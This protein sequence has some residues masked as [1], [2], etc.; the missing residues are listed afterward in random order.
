MAE[1]GQSKQQQQHVVEVDH[2]EQI[3]IWSIVCYCMF[4]AMLLIAVI[5]MCVNTPPEANSVEPKGLPT[6]KSMQAMAALEMMSK[7]IHIEFPCSII[8]WGNGTKGKR[9]LE[10][11]CASMYQGDDCVDYLQDNGQQCSAA[12]GVL[13]HTRGR[14]MHSL[15]LDVYLD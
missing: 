13:P 14:N 3:K 9:R 8:D 7:G 15:I 1:D 4:S 11:T 12:R 2:L 6:C 5:D 10:V